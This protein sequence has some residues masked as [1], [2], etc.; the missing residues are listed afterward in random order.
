M[1]QTPLEQISTLRI[2]TVDSV[3]PDRIEVSIDISAPESIALNTGT[4]RPFPRVNDYLLIP[5]DESFITGQVEWLTVERSA[6]PKRS[7]MRD[8][9][10]VDLPYPLRKL[11]LNP[12][13]TLRIRRESEDFVFRRGADVL[14]TV[15]EAVLLP[16]SNQ[17]R[18]IVESGEGNRVRIGTSLI[19]GNAGVYV[20][21]NRLFGRHVA[22]LGNTG[23]GKSCSV[24]GLIRWSL[25]QA[26]SWKDS[27]D[28]TVDQTAA[29]E[30]VPHLNSRFIVLDPNGEYASAFQESNSSIRTRVFK[31]N[32]DT[33]KGEVPLKVPLWFWNTTEWFSF[34]RA[35]SQAQQPLLRR[36]LREVKNAQVGINHTFTERR[37]LEL[38]RYL[39]SRMISLAGS[40]RT[41]EF[42]TEESRFGFRLL[43]IATDL[44]T[45][46]AEFT[47]INLDPI[48]DAINEA[49]GR[50][51]HEFYAPDGNFVQYY[52]AFT[53][54]DISGIVDALSAAVAGLGGVTY[55]EGQ[56]ED[57]PLPFSPNPPKCAVTAP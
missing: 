1:N 20:D 21:P 5:V 8:F 43:A 54:D 24:A 12:L 37:T 33:D 44:T 50:R 26:Q 11:R 57:A 34:A 15:G 23:S 46:N 13:G 4:P 31:V 56:S 39:S 17:L 52:R 51:Y 48:I 10:L 55:G 7:G 22:I 18:A 42:Q 6:F 30:D 40:L 45:K 9:G 16:T 35:S 27:Q 25:E 53:E 3:S 47:D 2:G 49:L 38:R 32:P 36:A 28:S 41:G 29:P 14:P 19:A